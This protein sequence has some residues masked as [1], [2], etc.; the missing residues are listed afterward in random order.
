MLKEKKENSDILIAKHDGTKRKTG[1]GKKGPFKF[2]DVVY[3]CATEFDNSR[4]SAQIKSQIRYCTVHND[5]GE[6]NNYLEKPVIGAF[7]YFNRFR[8]RFPLWFFADNDRQIR[9]L[10]SGA[11]V[12]N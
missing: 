11:F 1:V 8:D 10:K 5:I 4:H 12:T 2:L 6:S 3:Y 7:H 9:F